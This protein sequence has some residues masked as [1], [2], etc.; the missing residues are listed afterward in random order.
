MQFRLPNCMK[1]TY[2]Y[3]NLVTGDSRK[4]HS[5]KL[6]Y[7]VVKMLRYGIIN[8]STLN[9]LKA[10]SLQ[11]TVHVLQI[12][13]NILEYLQAHLLQLQLR[14]MLLIFRSSTNTTTISDLQKDLGIYLFIARPAS[15]SRRR[16]SMLTFRPPALQ[17]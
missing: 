7:L 15:H 11:N 10:W 17:G 6:G 16:M 2:L 5:D 12:F 1:V 14:C 9:A 3:I 4:I 8:G 13:H